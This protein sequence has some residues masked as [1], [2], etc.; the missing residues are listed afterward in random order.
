MRNREDALALVEAAFTQARRKRGTSGKPVG[1]GVLNNRLLQMTDRRFKPQDFGA[2][3]FKAFVMMLSPAFRLGGEGSR[4][5][6]EQ[7]SPL[8]TTEEPRGTTATPISR[9]D[10][11][12]SMQMLH[13]RPR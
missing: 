9:C 2:K 6:L 1:L 13:T 3:D 10:V 11:P 8:R 5:F 4:T 7:V 12:T